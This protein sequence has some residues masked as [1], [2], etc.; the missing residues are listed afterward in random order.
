MIALQDSIFEKMS[1]NSWTTGTRS[2]THSS[3]NLHKLLSTGLDFF[4]MLSSVAGIAGSG[5]QSNYAAGNTFQD[6]LAHHRRSIGLKA[7]SID[8]GVMGEIGIVA[9]TEAYT[10]SKEA[11]GDLAFIKEIEFL[12]LLDYYYDPIREF[13]H[14]RNSQPIIGLVTLDQFRE[15][16]VEPPEWIQR[17]MFRFLHQA[18]NPP[19]DASALEAN[20]NSLHNFAAELLAAESKSQG[21]AIVMAALLQKLSTTLTLAA[22]DIDIERPLHTYGVDSL[23][24]VEL[25]NWFAKVFQIDIAVFDITSQRSIKTFVSQVLSKVDGLNFQNVSLGDE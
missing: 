2:K 13:N 7:T 20:G 16:G 11:F 15:M 3:L 17:P 9:E 10:R 12:A 8:L 22:M 25:G 5:G 4:I 1:F 24:A 18:E 21:E 14:V 6:P 19:K 23:L